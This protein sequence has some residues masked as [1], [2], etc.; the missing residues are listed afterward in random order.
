MHRRTRGF[1]TRASLRLRASV[2]GFIC[3]CTSVWQA[4]LCLVIFTVCVMSAAFSCFC[5]PRQ[6]D[7]VLSCCTFLRLSHAFA[8]RICLADPGGFFPIW[9]IHFGFMAFVSFALSHNV[10]T[11]SPCCCGF[12]FASDSSVLLPHVNCCDIP[13]D[14][15]L[16]RSRFIF[17]LFA[18][19]FTDARDHTSMSF[20]SE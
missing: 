16:C 19:E 1:C 14:S 4:F 12:P 15:V 7:S 17:N 13:R 8:I 18:G 10:Q 9:V 6:F 11:H 20:V 5:D 2:S 3:R